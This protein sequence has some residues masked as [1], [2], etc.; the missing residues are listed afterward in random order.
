[1]PTNTT[2]SPDG[3]I[4]KESRLRS[5]SPHRSLLLK[6]AQTSAKR[7]H[8]RPHSSKPSGGE[9]LTRNVLVGLTVAGVAQA[10]LTTIFR[11]FHVDVFL[12]AYHLPLSSYA[13]GSL[14]V[15]MV[16]TVSTLIGAWVLDHR[17]TKRYRHDHV[18]QAGCLFVLCFLT[19]FFRLSS[20]QWETAHFVSIRTPLIR[21]PA[22]SP[23]SHCKIALSLIFLI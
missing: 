10:L 17:A 6:P 13:N 16:T 19:P 21:Q 23:Q 1:M 12:Q 15:S 5:R 18:G 2:T 20:W 14:I 22:T 11:L 3:A 8:R 4:K 7:R 9:V